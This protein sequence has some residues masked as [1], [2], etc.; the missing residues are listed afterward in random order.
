[1][2]TAVSA[3]AGASSVRHA[4]QVGTGAVGTGAVATSRLVTG[5][6]A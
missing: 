3:S 2:T 1:M 5:A 4:C 6:G